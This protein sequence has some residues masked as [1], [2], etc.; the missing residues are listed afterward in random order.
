MKVLVECF[1]EWLSS[2]R[3][4]VKAWTYLEALTRETLKKIGA[5]DPAQREF[6][7]ED[8]VHAS[9][10]E[11]AW[12]Y[13]SAKRRVS[14]A[15]ID[16]FLEARRTALEAYFRERGHEQGVRLGYRAM[17]GRHRAV[18]FLTAYELPVVSAL[19]TE[20]G[21]PDPPGSASNTE[22]VYE[23]AGP[24]QVRPSA[25]L[26]RL[27]LGEGEIST[28]SVRGVLWLAV[29]IGSVSLIAA[30]AYLFFI[31]HRV[32]RP[33]TTSDLVL[34]VMLAGAGYLFWRVGLR[35]W[36]WLLDDRIVTAGELLVAL[37]EPPAQ[38]ELTKEKRFRLVRFTGTCPICAG[39]IELRYGHGHQ[40]RRLFG[41]CSEAPQDHVFTFDRVLRRGVRCS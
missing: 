17:S 12:D 37:R 14:T 28:R 5:Q 8:L 34:L 38:L 22:L 20:S 10:P 4:D 27:L 15:K 16:L 31:M 18:W 3:A 29:I 41:C 19:T 39:D 25:V 24:G 7:A 36:L 32:Q 40:R 33:L 9:E 1:F 2:N 21:L 26:G 30:C 23:M 35:P 11:A 13:E 6:D